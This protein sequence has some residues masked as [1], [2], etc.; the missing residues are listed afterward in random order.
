MVGQNAYYLL[1]RLFRD[2]K[3]NP[4]RGIKEW[5]DRV[6]I[7]PTHIPFVINNALDKK[8]AEN[9][10][11]TEQEMQEILDTS[12]PRNYPGEFTSKD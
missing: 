10:L 3:V 5:G 12:L 7:L 9:Q 8:G 6:K 1:R 11:F 2:Y 4:S